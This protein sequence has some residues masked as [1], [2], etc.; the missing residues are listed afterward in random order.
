MFEKLGVVLY[1]FFFGV[2]PSVA[3]L[4]LLVF[5][6]YWFF[7]RDK[8]APA[9][10]GQT[11][12]IPLFGVACL[13][14]MPTIIPWIYKKY[15]RYRALTILPSN[16]VINGLD[17]P[18]GTRLLSDS[19]DG[20]EIKKFWSMQFPREADP[21]IWN[22]IVISSVVVDKIFAVPLK[23]QNRVL[24]YGT[25]LEIRGHDTGRGTRSREPYYS[26]RFDEYRFKRKA[27]APNNGSLAEKHYEFH[28]CIKE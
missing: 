18:K 6:I 2:L 25:Y 26:C 22:R 27:D 7:L 4:L 19:E 13:I 17:L 5:P 24:P 21:L 16:Q 10:V 23:E 8:K 14:W 9:S 20:Y 28:S 11:L 15:D 3:F 1:V 12:S